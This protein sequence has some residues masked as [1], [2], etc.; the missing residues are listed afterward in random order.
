MANRVLVRKTP[1]VHVPC[2][3][4]TTR[5]PEAQ[6]YNRDTPDCCRAHIR[7]VVFTVGD[8]L[9]EAGIP[10]WLDYGSLLGAFRNPQL[11]V[12]LPGGM[13]PF[14]K[15]AD[16]GFLASDWDRVLAIGGGEWSEPNKERER[17]KLALGLRWVHKLPKGDLQKPEH[18]WLGGDSLKVQRSEANH[19][20][21]DFFAWHERSD[22]KFDRRRY[23]G[24][25]KN[26]GRALPKDWL[27]PL[28]EIEWEGRM[29]PCPARPDLVIPYRY[30][31]QK[32]PLRK[33]NWGRRV[34]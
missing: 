8:A 16:C 13:I 29:L 9:T 11:K 30:P 34:N 5:C 20:N 12:P 33:N 25:D 14:D 21:C 2:T 24:V 27:L 4:E 19:S 23:L 18:L 26:K 31:D 28:G 17:F 32:V 6:N 1:K 15:D 3:A 7:H 10:W 22:G